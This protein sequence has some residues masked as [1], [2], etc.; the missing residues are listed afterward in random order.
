MKFK[1]L[2]PLTALVSL[3]GCLGTES[4]DKS[5]GPN[6]PDG[7][8]ATCYWE[9]QQSVQDEC[10]RADKPCVENHY[11]EVGER[12]GLESEC[13]DVVSSLSMDSTSSDVV[14]S[15]S[16]AIISSSSSTLN[17]G[18]VADYPFINN[19]FDISGNENNPSV[20]GATLSN[21]RFNNINNAYSF[22]GIDDKMTIQNSSSLSFTDGMTLVIWLKIDEYYSTGKEHLIF[23]KQEN[24]GASQVGCHLQLSDFSDVDRLIYRC[25]NGQ[26]SNWASVDSD[27]SNLTLGA[28]NQIVITTNDSKLKLY[29][30][31]QLQD[32]FPITSFNNVGMSNSASIEIGGPWNSHLSPQTYFNGSLD[33]IRIYNRALS[34]NEITE[35]YSLQQ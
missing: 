7:F 15:S 3:V 4:D 35:L 22:D 26:G 8:S 31:N 33:D 20:N 24:I 9:N 21:D 27:W 16:S 6:L 14:S 29:I 23:H 11:L 19:S 32:E 18:L 34:Q 1:Y 10:G 25:R 5:E 2:L 13:S 28:F 12:A 17:E 30:N